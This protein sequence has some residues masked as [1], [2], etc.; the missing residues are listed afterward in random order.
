MAARFSYR[1]ENFG[2][3]NHHII[4]K[5]SY[6]FALGLQHLVRIPQLSFPPLL[7][8]NLDIDSEWC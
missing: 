3:F 2:Y 4:G 6:C 8:L 1:Y 5:N 7:Y